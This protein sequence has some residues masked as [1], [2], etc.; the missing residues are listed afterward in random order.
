MSK[1][2]R[3]IKWLIL[4]MAALLI[5]ASPSI[6]ELADEAGPCEWGMVLCSL[7]AQILGTFSDYMVRCLIGYAFCKKYIE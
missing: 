4:G 5:F 7:D 1:R 3:A 2:T 6:A